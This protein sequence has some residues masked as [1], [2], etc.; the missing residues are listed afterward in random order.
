MATGT[1]EEEEEK[2]PEVDHPVYIEWNLR[3]RDQIS[4]NKM[5]GKDRLEHG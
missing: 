1:A 3:V 2:V 4:E 5:V